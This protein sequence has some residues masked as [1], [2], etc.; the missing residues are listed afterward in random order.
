MFDV[1]LILGTRPEA[2]KLIPVY[3]NLIKH[4]DFSVQL[5][6]TG[7]HREMLNEV[8]SFFEVKP[9]IDLG[10]MTQNQTLSQF[11]SRAMMELDQLLLSRPTKLLIVQGDTTTAMVSALVAY[12][13]KIR[14]AHV[15]AGLRTNNKY[16]P[17][18]EEFNRRAISILADY[19]Y[20]PT[21][22]AKNVLIKEGA[23]QV[24]LT[25]NTGIDSLLFTKS[26]VQNATGKYQNQFKDI[27]NPQKNILITGHRRESFGNGFEIICQSILTL[28]QTLE[29]YNFIYPL[30]LNPN[31]KQVVEARLSAQKN[32]FLIDQLS[33]DAMV[34]LMTKSKLILTDSGG[35]QEEAPTLNVPV[36]VMRD[37]SERMEGVD[38]GCCVLAGVSTNMVDCVLKIL[39]DSSLYQKMSDAKSPY[40]DGNA[41]MKIVNH[42]RLNIID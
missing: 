34:Y 33:Y 36:V 8:F 22:H 28:S 23:E 42:L 5:I 27:L 31:V 24:V 29:D 2:I 25:G 20:A 18:P 9:D 6:S 14:V 15:E 30:H 17:F 3:I 41:A 32:I 38:A 21:E 11:T 40:G 4:T 39:N 13:H 12:Y 19:H 1:T 35:I 7:Q 26:K 37:E 16:G 10:L